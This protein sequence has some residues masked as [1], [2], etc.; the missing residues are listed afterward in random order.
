MENKLPVYITGLLDKLYFKYCQ[1][2]KYHSSLDGRQCDA[3]LWP[4]YIFEW[5]NWDKIDNN[6]PGLKLFLPAFCTE[7]GLPSIFF[8]KRYFFTVQ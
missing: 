5:P 7:P 3:Y 2:D 6:S 4:N 1:T 8:F